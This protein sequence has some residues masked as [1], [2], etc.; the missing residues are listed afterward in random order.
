M[1]G[2]CAKSSICEAFEWVIRT[3]I[4]ESLLHPGESL[5]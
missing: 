3:G 1:T 5:R 4:T 2:G